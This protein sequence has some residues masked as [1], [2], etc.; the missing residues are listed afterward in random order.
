MSSRTYDIQGFTLCLDKI[1]L[2]SAVFE[3]ENAEGWQFNIRLMGDVRVRV[4][5]PDRPAALLERQLLVRALNDEI[6]DDSEE[7]S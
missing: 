3:A 2:L 6:Q 5:L 7:S 4:K 1:V